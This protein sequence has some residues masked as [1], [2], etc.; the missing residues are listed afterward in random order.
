MSRVP[1]TAPLSRC[2]L[3]WA[4]VSLVC[5]AALVALLPDLRRCGVLLD[6]GALADA[7]FDRALALLAVVALTGSAVWWWAVTS[8]AVLEAATAVRVRGCPPAMRRVVL[9]AC[10]VTL[11][12]GLSPAVA[13]QSAGLPPRPADPGHSVLAGLQL[14]DRSPGVVTRPATAGATSAPGAVRVRAGDSLWSIAEGSLGHDADDAS[15]DAR[16][17]QIWQANREVVGAD[18]DLIHP[19]TR[20][21][22]PRSRASAVRA[23]TVRS[24]TD[25][26]AREQSAEEK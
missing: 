18:P 13:D 12:S 26:S 15:I 7:P 8:L 21:R 11:A 17:R 2:L 4:G 20:L 5:L 9:L 16:W 23:S 6:A 19:G 22:L 25:Q 1:H 3:V 24:S 10:G 14:P